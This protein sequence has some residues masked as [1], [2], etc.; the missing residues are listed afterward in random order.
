MGVKG[1]TVVS[2]GTEFVSGVYV[3]VYSR[4][5]L[6]GGGDGRTCWGV[7]VSSDSCFAGRDPMIV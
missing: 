6:Q 2:G 5:L 1:T 4:N 7:I 3:S